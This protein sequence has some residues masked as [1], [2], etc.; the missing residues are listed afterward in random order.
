M[1]SEDMTKLELLTA[2]RGVK[3]LIADLSESLDLLAQR[4]EQATKLVKKIDN[5]S[6]NIKDLT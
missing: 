3:R 1:S 6:E 2:L 5:I 4:L